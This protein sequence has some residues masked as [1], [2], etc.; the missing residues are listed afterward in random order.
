M[1][2]FHVTSGSPYEN[3]IGF[4][5]AVRTGSIISISGTAP[6]AMDGSTD[7]PGDLYGQTLRCLAIINDAIESLGGRLEHV[8]RT[9]VFL[10]DISRWEEA[11]K[12]HGQV[13][14]DVRPAS[15][16][17]EVSRLINPEWLVEIEAEA[18]VD[19]DEN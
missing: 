4:S 12:A 1:P 3:S 18:I 10:T 6:I 9:R 15:T 13:F 11:A 19:T 7:F 2:R 8:T 17:V 5:R 16:F 14:A